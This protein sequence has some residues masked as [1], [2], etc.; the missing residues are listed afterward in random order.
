[1][2]EAPTK[3]PGGVTF[4]G[5]LVIIS[6][7]LYI[8]S[9]IIALV[10]AASGAGTATQ[11]WGVLI[12]GIA[13]IIFGVIELAV[14]RGLFR[15]NNVSRIIVAIVNVLT[16]ISGLF[17]AFQPGNQRGVSFTQVAIAIIILA[18]LYSPRANAF[19]GQSRATTTL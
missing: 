5:V 15:G 14:A 1:M 18:V 17:A 11:S 8:L 12:P 4:I 10:V 6:G 19:F 13:I 16:I 2:S 7:I 3:R 9:G